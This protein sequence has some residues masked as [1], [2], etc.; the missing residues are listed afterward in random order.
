MG[1]KKKQYKRSGKSSAKNRKSI[2]AEAMEFFRENSGKEFNYKQVSAR[3]NVNDPAG[4]Q[5]VL[6]TLRDLA[7][8]D[9]LKQ[10]SVGKFSVHPSQVAAVEG[11]IDFTKNGSA[12]V[13]TESDGKDIF[14]QERNTFTA[15]NGDKVEVT[16]L[17][18]NRG[19][20]E[21]KVTGIVSRNSEQYVGIV[22]VSERHTFFVPSNGKI[23]VDFFID[24]NK[25]NGAKNGEK[26][27]VRL[28]DWPD[29]DKSPFAEVIDVLGSPG[30]NNV[31]MHAI[32][33]E[34]GLPY[35]FPQE[36]L[37]AAQKIDVTISDQEVARR[38]DMRGIPTF[39]IDPDDAKDFDDALSFRKLENGRTEVG[40]HIADV[41]HY[42]QPDSIIDNEAVKRATS[43][44]LVDRVVPML[45]EVLS[46]YVCSLRPDEDKLC[47][48]AIFE[49]SEDWSVK[50]SFFGRTVIRSQRRF[51]YDDAQKVIETGKGDFS[52]E[53]TELHKR[54]TEMRKERMRKGALEFGGIEV[55]FKLDENGKPIGV[56]QKVMKEANWLV[57]EFMLLANKKVAEH[58]GKPNKGEQAKTFV[59]RI[60]DLP[61]S[62]K[63]KTLK[64]FVGR[65]GYKLS[66]T[67]PE[68]ASRALNQLMNQL[69]G[70]PEEDIVKQMAIRTMSKAV[71]STENIGH[72][73]LAFSHY[74]HFTS[75]IRRYPDVMAHRLMMLYKN[76]G[77]SA[78]ADEI[79]KS[80]KHSSQMEKK[81]TDAE[82][83]SIK[84]K[85]VEF[86]MN[87]IG[88]VFEG[89]V[90]GLTRWGMYVE[91]V[92]NKCEGMVPLNSMD[93]D[94]YKYDERKHQIV[95]TKYKEVYEFGDKVKVKVQG[96]DLKQKQLDFRIV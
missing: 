42:V 24:N 94:I 86:M 13:V 10:P 12:Y 15:L 51:T 21:G 64:D 8:M 14:I 48:S 73:G 11:I 1:N 85:Q 33:V 61:D 28:L 84:Y 52:N 16:L 57:E 74:S 95:G 30:D 45:P 76:G 81:A 31:E 68:Q 23:H 62:D 37:D 69:K 7:R 89:A 78:K 5:L 65:L 41:A 35:E 96:A 80:C 22:E 75:P 4:R 26:V 6:D 70:K 82:R 39:T 18:K 87:K 34:F 83:A 63:L 19:Q 55:K 46:N 60:H 17:K 56:Y 29:P 25:L 20:M 91:L 44:Y 77:K 38:R 50:K 49:M 93:D 32:L 66:S 59:Y 90:S 92:E 79:E 9:M 40:I 53:I 2:T 67:E 43:V 27:I 72:Y 47:M 58:I 54:A 3:L 88:E 36:V 71:Y